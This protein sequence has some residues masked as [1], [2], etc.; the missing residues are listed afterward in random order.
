VFHLTSAGAVS[1][2][3]FAQAVFD[4][5]PDPER[6]LQTLKPIATA[7]YP[8]RAARPS[9]SRLSCARLADA[10]HV[11]LPDWRSALRLSARDFPLR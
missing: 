3:G 11:A 6:T 10:W 9:N 7:E 5:I 2:F 4:A 8:T 1:W